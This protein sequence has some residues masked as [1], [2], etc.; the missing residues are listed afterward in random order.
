MLAP[1][2]RFTRFPFRA[3]AVDYGAKITV[4]ELVNVVGLH[5]RF[6]GKRHYQLEQLITKAPNEESL[7]LQLFGSDP[8]FFGKVAQEIDESF[9]YK[10]I[11]LNTGC[12]KPNITSMGAGAAL[13]NNVDN[14][15]A[16]LT[17]LT[18]HSSLPITVKTR[19]GWDR[20]TIYDTLKILNDFDIQ[21][22]TVHTRL[23]TES[24]KTPAHK[25]TI[26]DI[27][28]AANM[29]VFANGDVFTVEDIKEYLE[30]GAYG[31]AIGRKAKT[32]PHIFA[33]N[34]NPTVVQKFD[35]VS[36]FLRYC[37]TSNVH[38]L[39]LAFI[40]TITLNL[41]KGIPFSNIAKRSINEAKNLS[42]L[43][44]IISTLEEKT[45]K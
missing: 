3:L 25:E 41:I 30:Y 22:L 14:L 17:Q 45:Q 35:A 29:P 19:L 8:E 10:F 9:G 11:E 6:Q 36:N 1:M 2:A 5:Y 33:F 32:C 24:Y 21:W 40:K 15:K 7:G 12:P 44:A 42:E 34:D 28:S 39:S 23:V 27:V 26:L 13:L 18:K 16:I 4:T 43:Y 37:E 38:G 20:I 31:V